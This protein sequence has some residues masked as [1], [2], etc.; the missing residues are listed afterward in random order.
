M[1]NNLEFIA[2]LLVCAG[3][4]YLVRMLPLALVKNKIKNRFLKCTD[5][6][7]ND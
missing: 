1:M 7:I 4:T 5:N 6:F 3:V 2:Y